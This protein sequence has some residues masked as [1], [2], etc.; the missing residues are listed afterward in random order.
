[1]GALWAKFQ[2]LVPFVTKFRS[3]AG[4]KVGGTGRRRALSHHC[5]S[6]PPAWECQATFLPTKVKGIRFPF[7]QS[8]FL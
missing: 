2:P 6:S 4:G 8:M 1:M 7:V 5:L 3:H